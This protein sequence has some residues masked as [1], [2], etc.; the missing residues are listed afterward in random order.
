[1]KIKQICPLGNDC[2]TIKDNEVV[3]CQWYIALKGK[4]PQSEDVIDKW[5]CAMS[6][7]PIL[8]IENA[9]TNRGQ[10]QALESFRNEM[11]K[12]QKVFNRVVS[13]GVEQMVSLKY[14]EPRDKDKNNG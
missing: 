2:E 3:R 11:V 5:N 8:L 6:W 1:M 13:S 7:L 12:E 10:T 9:Q 4:D 14:L